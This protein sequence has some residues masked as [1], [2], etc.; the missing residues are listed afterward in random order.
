MSFGKWLV[1]KRNAAGLTQEE[2][3]D[4]V[5]ISESYVSALERDEPNSRD[6]SPRRLRIDKVDKLARPLRV[7][8]DE[9]RLAAGYAPKESAGFLFQINE[10]TGWDEL[11]P[12]QQEAVK[13]LTLSAIRSLAQLSGS[14]TGKRVKFISEERKEETGT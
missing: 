1:E 12:D 11:T 2:L 9:A 5:G 7:T 8:V 3:A 6:G 4:F 10:N 13:E 14:K